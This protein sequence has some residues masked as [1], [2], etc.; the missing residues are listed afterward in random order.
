[1]FVPGVP[2][3]ENS[4]WT[5]LPTVSLGQEMSLKETVP[6]EKRTAESQRILSAWPTG[7]AFDGPVNVD[8]C[9]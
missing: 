5:L 6:F 2:M 9:G 3:V 8:G 1:M 7:S 4:M